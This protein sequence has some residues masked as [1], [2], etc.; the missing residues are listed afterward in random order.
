MERHFTATAIVLYGRKTLLHLHPKLDRWLSP[1]GHLEPN[2]LPHEAALRE[3]KEETGLDLALI[4][5]TRLHFA[6]PNAHSLPLPFHCLLETISAFGNQPAHQHVD[7]IFLAAP[8]AIEQIAAI[9]SSFRW[10]TYPELEQIQDKLF[11]ESLALLQQA[12]SQLE[13]IIIS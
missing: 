1:G 3:A 2:E 10:F 5:S 4:E 11:P 7:F 9:P 6:A 13:S 12:F 8:L